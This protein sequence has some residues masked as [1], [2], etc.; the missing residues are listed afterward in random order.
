MFQEVKTPI[1]GIVE[2]MSG[3]VCPCCNTV[4]DIFGSDGGKRT[5]EKYGVELL[6]QVPIEPP[7]ASAA[8]TAF[9]SSSPRPTR[10][11][12]KPSPTPRSASPPASPSK[13]SR[14]RANRRSC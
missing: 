3:F 7:S 11:P 14:N 6:G 9:P 2:N 10:S 13:P 4:T 8:M 5:A 12:A 1:L